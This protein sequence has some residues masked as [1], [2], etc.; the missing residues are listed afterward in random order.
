[1]RARSKLSTGRL[2]LVV[3]SGASAMF[4]LASCVIDFPTL[5]VAEGGTSDASTSDATTADDGSRADAGMTTTRF[6]EGGSNPPSCDDFDDDNYLQDGAPVVGTSGCKLY[7]VGDDYLSAPRSLEPSTDASAGCQAFLGF[8]VTLAA[9]QTIVV[10]GAIKVSDFSAAATP[11]SLVKITSP[12]GDTLSLQMTANGIIANVAGTAVTPVS[13][14]QPGA[15]NWFN[16]EI[17]ARLQDGTFDL[18]VNGTTAI[19]N[20]AGIAAV[21]K[22]DAG[23]ADAGKPAGPVTI[24]F[25]ADRPKGEP[26]VTIHIDNITIQSQ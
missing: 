19:P 17:D 18:K 24:Y 4:A 16:V 15:G 21:K 23:S 2:A 7:V 26:D 20:H 25:G 1:M 12:D 6:C 10:N 8:I 9:N 11:R 13:P 3:V 22:T 5:T 14:Q